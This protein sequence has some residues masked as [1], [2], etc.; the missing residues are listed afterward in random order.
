M[1][2]AAPSIRQIALSGLADLDARGLEDILGR[3]LRDENGDVRKIAGENLLKRFKSTAKS[4]FAAQAQDTIVRCELMH[5]TTW[6]NT[7]A[8]QLT[9]SLSF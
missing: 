8:M 3:A 7:S 5:C 2:D 4:R 9:R 1:K 6:L